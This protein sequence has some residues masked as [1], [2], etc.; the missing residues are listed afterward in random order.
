MKAELFFALSSRLFEE[1]TGPEIAFL[2]LEA[3]TSSF[4]RLNKGRVRQPGDVEQHVATLSLLRGQKQASSTLSLAGNT[5][6]DVPAL[7]A[8]LLDLRALLDVVPDDPF[9][10][11]DTAPRE[12]VETKEGPLPDPAAA[13]RFAVDRARGLDL[14]GIWASGA[15]TRG[16]SSS[17]GH[18][19][20]RTTHSFS[21]DFSVYASPDK[22]V[23]GTYAGTEFDPQ[24]LASRLSRAAAELE[25]LRRPERRLDPGHYRAFLSPSA[26]AELL[27]LLS[28]DAF[29]EKAHRTKQ[30]P[31][32]SMIEEGASLDP[33]VTISE[34]A[35]LGVAPHFLP[36]GFA[37]PPRVPLIEGGKLEGTLVSPRSAR[38]YG[39]TVN[40]STGERPSSLSMEPGDLDE[41]DVLRRLG[42]GILIPNLWYA[43]YSDAPRGRITAMTRFA[44]MW[45]EDGV[46]VAPLAVLRFDDTLFR[47]FGSELEALTS[48]CEWHLDNGSYGGRGTT[49]YSLPGA[50][51]RSMT[52][53]L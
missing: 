51:I 37:R 12:S 35:E 10:T 23:K 4:V 53:T 44:T 16:L 6:N 50:L 17:L 21:L 42:T 26:V 30:T 7:R 9:S 8:A 33:R 13:T 40:A 29:G 14:V 3:E 1:L 32:L 34:N 31:F 41:K 27:G 11:F 48:G 18:R 36:F 24:E 45:V 25:I 49:S 46:V 43:N 22:A 5:E 15:I 39:G 38:E 2:W 52:F 47:L 19:L 20:Y 28:Y